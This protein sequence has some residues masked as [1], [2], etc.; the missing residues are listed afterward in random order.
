MAISISR[1]RI[2]MAVAMCLLLVIAASGCGNS[3]DG[4]IDTEL[5]VSALAALV[6]T[7]ISTY[8]NSL[9]TLAMTQEVQSTDWETMEDLLAEVEESHV[10]GTVWFVLPD[11][12]YYTVEQGLTDNNLS[13]RDYFPGLMAGSDV[14]GDL[15]VSKST[16]KKSLIAASPVKTGEE[17]VGGVGASIFLEDLS[18]TL[19]DEIDL[20]S[21]M[22]F[23]AV[24]ADGEVVLHSDADMIMAGDPSLS[25]NVVTKTSTL[26][27]W[28][29]ALGFKD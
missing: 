20:P 3:E 1:T 24:T 25:T 9:D 10:Q 27:G 4:K 22:T 12:S 29:V 11:G 5:G 6:D 13:D 23:H 15:V 26:T 28:T 18:Q 8:L 2:M 7:H 16:G 21:D 19:A 17:V 14:L